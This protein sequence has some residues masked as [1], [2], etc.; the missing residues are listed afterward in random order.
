M[1]NLVI[2]NFDELSN[3][4]I[5]EI[6]RARSQVFI[7]EE[8]MNCQ[9]MD[10]IDFHSRHYFIEEQGR[11]L[12]YMRVYYEDETKK[13]IKIGR[14][15]SIKRLVGLGRKLFESSLFDIKGYFKA[16]KIVLHSQKQAIVFYEKLGFKVIS[17]EY[18]EEDVV[19]TTMM[20]KI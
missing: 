7:V 20:L 19:H 4:E 1:M 13:T 5:Y 11:V 10:Y 15:L 17:D 12:S 6:L 9:D 8:K 16:D 2:K 3:R 14:V 18:L